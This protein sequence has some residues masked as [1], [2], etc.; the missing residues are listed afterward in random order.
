MLVV[1]GSIDERDLA[2]LELDLRE[3]ETGE[4]EG[5]YDCDEREA[6]VAQ[7]KSSAQRWL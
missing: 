2:R 5:G 4:E 3:D 6:A 7:R 1:G